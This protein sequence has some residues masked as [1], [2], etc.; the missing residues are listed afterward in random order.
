MT[1]TPN[2]SDGLPAFLPQSLAPLWRGWRDYWPSNRRYPELRLLAACLAAPVLT[3]AAAALIYAAV[4]YGTE[5][6]IPQPDHAFRV[7]EDT[8]ESFHDFIDVFF[9]AT[10]MWFPLALAL[11]VSSDFR[12]RRAYG[13]AGLAAAV[14]EFSVDTATLGTP[15]PLLFIGAALL[16][17]ALFLTIRW[18]AGVRKRPR[19]TAA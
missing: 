17:P 2:A 15:R 11:L 14:A 5:L 19:P 16:Y 3:S 4:F 13:I 10:L 9:R 18:L 7:V 6:V 12:S 1:S 8:V